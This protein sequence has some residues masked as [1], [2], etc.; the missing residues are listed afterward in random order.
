MQYNLSVLSPL[1]FEVLCNDIISKKTGLIF[2]RYKS[3]IDGGIDLR[4]TEKGIICQCK[5]YKEFSNLKLALKKEVLKLDGID[6]LKEYFLIVS[7][8]LTPSNENDI[9]KI[10]KK[11]NLQSDHIISYTTIEDFLN[12]PENSEILKKN[13]KLW[14]T[15]ANTLKIFAEKYIDF[16]VSSLKNNIEK[17]SKYF[18]ETN[19][20]NRCY[21]IL[22]NYRI[23]V[24]S[25]SP[26]VGKTINSN[27]L[28]CK[29]IS[30]NPNLRVKVSGGSNYKALIESF[31]KDDEEIIILD[32]FL[33][34]SYLEKNNDQINEIISIIQYVKS[35]N[36]KYL[37]LNSR[38]SVLTDAKATSEKL[39]K[40]ISELD[41]NKYVI[42]MNDISLI[43]KAEILYNLHYFNGVPIEYYNVLL[44]EEFL[45]YYRYESII[46]NVNYNTRIIEHCTL[47]YKKD[48]ITVDKYYAY[49]KHNLDNPKEIWKMQFS[50]LRPEERAFLNIL[51]SISASN[52][53]V[54][55]LRK[56]FN[57]TSKNRGY[58]TESNLFNNILEKMS[59]SIIEQKIINNGYVINVYNPSINDFIMNDL[60]DNVV[61]VEKM[62]NDIVYI[63]QL[64]RLFKLNSSFKN[65]VS[66]KILDLLS[67][68]NNYDY[69]LFYIISKYSFYCD[70]IK[71]YI[72]KKYNNINLK[73]SNFALDILSDKNLIKLYGLEKY[74]FDVNVIKSICINADNVYIRD[75]IFFLDDY[76]FINN[77][78]V[79][80]E[81]LDELYDNLSDIIAD[82]IECDVSNDIFLEMDDI[83]RR[84]IVSCNVIIE[85]EDSLVVSNMD[86][87]IELIIND[88]IPI[89]EE[90]INSEI[91][92][93]YQ[94]TI[95]F[96]YINAST[97]H[98]YE[99][100][101][102]IDLVYENINEQYRVES[103]VDNSVKDISVED[104]LFQQYNN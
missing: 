82:K 18:V 52:V 66:I 17:Y 38:L 45:G 86:E 31:D 15:S 68:N 20:F 40:I 28:V 53:P 37:I 5:H 57:K 16:E 33:G 44:K 96:K 49:I 71:E 62:L 72:Y 93:Y 30:K 70:E 19:V 89:I 9:I 43:E 23:L 3:G 51:Y 59:D 2:N 63:E 21:D 36:N 81:F 47:N 35:Y 24:I 34:Q 32:D 77:I 58:R 13:L 42:D 50:F 79:S 99:T 27:M 91:E 95:K 73:Y 55:V 54:D 92:W 39:E 1:E 67:F 84:H 97:E 85:D 26:G 25:G 87:V 12:H 29:M 56:C 7:T 65:S 4:N 64:E 60:K 94:H 48:G 75:F 69:T 102:L 61:E 46:K 74:L 80:K 90:K 76:I 41:N 103:R 101:T 8:S 14:L 78:D 104:V 98:C 11:Y 88:I 10:Y 22:I 6:G 100:E 83:V